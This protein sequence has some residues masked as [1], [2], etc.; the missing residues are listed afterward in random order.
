M[1][2]LIEGFWDCPYCGQK[3]IGGL[4]KTCPNCNT[5]RG[6]NIKFYMDD[7]TN[8]VTDDVAKKVSKNPDWLCTYCD[9]LNSDDLKICRVCGAEKEESK[10][11]Y[12]E[13]RKKQEEHKRKVE[14][15]YTTT[16]T[17]VAEQKNSFPNNNFSKNSSDNFSPNTKHNKPVKKKKSFSSKFLKI[18]AISLAAILLITGLVCLF[19]PKTQEGI[20]DSFSWSRSIEVEEYKTVQESDWSVPPGGRTLYTQREIKTYEQVLDHYETKTRTYTEEVL[21]HYEDYVSGHR[22]LGN[23]MFEEIISQRPVYRT[24]TKTETYQEPVYRQE[25]VYATKYYYEIDKWMHKDY[26][27]TSG[28]DKDP[29]WGEYTFKDKEREGTKSEDYKI[30]ITNKDGKKKE[31]SVDFDVWNKLN[32]GDSV[33]LKVYIGGKAELITE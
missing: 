28:S 25:P 13:N 24:E 21:D 27:K 1:G 26:V 30:H 7:P 11:D 12:F 14:N 9:S 23:G 20:V 8:Y 10:S 31:Y 17:S 29:Y 15:A 33:K 22:D 3:R 18:G 16:S 19:M 6:K 32:Q 2:K 4:T 5:P